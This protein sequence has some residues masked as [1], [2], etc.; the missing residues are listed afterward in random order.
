MLVD[1]YGNPLASERDYVPIFTRADGRATY[2]EYYL[3]PFSTGFAYIG[4]DNENDWKLNA[5]DES[6][7]STQKAATLI[8]IFINSSPDLDRALHDMYQFCNCLL[9]TSP[10]PR[11]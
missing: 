8:E 1:Q 6:Q 7:L 2:D 5:I 9:Y 4:P 3:T 10:S 11:D